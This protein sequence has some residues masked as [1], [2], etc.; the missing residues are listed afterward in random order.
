M[1]KRVVSR[2][3]MAVLTVLLL[4]ISVILHATTSNRE[5]DVVQTSRGELRIMP[6]FHGSVMLEFGGKVIHIDPW[7]QGDYTGLPQADLIII[8]HTHLDHLDRQMFDKLR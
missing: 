7:S 6:I 3:A 2:V 1:H 4:A 8:T 5:T